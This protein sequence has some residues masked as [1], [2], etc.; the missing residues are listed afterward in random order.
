M[1]R[2]VSTIASAAAAVA[3]VVACG[4]AKERSGFGPETA[5]NGTFNDGGT[6]EAGDG[7][8]SRPVSDPT[9]C[10]EAL[11]AKTYVGC[12]YWPTV[13]ANLVSDVFDLAR[14]QEAASA[15]EAAMKTTATTAI[16][17]KN[18][19]TILSPA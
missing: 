15:W 8:G 19:C 16:D 12:D 9:T 10:E 4:S 14:E 17:V 18:R 13:T 11:Q 2:T 1:N 3:L 6:F 5:V 7:S